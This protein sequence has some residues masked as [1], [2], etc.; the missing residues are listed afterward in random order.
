M[1]SVVVSRLAGDLVAAVEAPRSVIIC[2]AP[3]GSGKLS[4]LVSAII[5]LLAPSSEKDCHALILCPNV[6]AAWY[7]YKKFMFA[8]T[9]ASLR[10]LTGTLLLPKCVEEHAERVDELVEANII[11]APL[12][13]ITSLA[14][15]PVAGL[16]SVRIV[17]LTDC[18][19]TLHYWNNYR[20]FFEQ[21]SP[22]RSGHF[23][24]VLGLT[25]KLNSESRAMCKSM[26]NLFAP[27]SAHNLPSKVLFLSIILYYIIIIVLA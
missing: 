2:E 17:A 22:R 16:R 27:S 3:C 25:A 20:E 7:T 26:Y 24:T 6:D 4:A 15:H 21:M 1:S 10:R 18:F 23:R 5:A 14:S 12:S 19:R 9:A 11:V 8:C 13:I